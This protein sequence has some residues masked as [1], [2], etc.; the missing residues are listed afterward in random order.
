MSNCQPDPTQPQ[1]LPCD[2][3]AFLQSRLGVGP[4]PRPMSWVNGS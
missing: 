4:R 2:F 1:E 3:L